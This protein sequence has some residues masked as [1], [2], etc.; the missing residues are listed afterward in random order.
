MVP[1]LQIQ[2]MRIQVILHLEIRLIILADIVADQRDR[3]NQRKVFPAI[4]INDFLQFL[5]FIG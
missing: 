2:R 5:L 3:N 4:L 1:H